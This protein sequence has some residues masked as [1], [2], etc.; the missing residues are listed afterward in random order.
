MQKSKYVSIIFSVVIILSMLLAGCQSA[1]EPVADPSAEPEA[2]APAAEAEAP[3]AVEE[4]EAPAPAAEPEVA[5]EPTELFV[6]LSNEPSN[7]EPAVNGGTAQRAVKLLIYRGLYNYGKDGALTPELASS[8]DISDD[9]LTYT[10]HLIDAVFHNGDPV[11]ADDVKFTFD[12]IANEET[13]ATFS[14]QLSVID[15]VNVVDEKTVEFVLSQP[16][17]PL[18]D[19]LALPESVIVSKNYSEANGGDINTAPVGAGPYSFVEYS[20][21]QRV[22]VQKF[23]GYYKEG[24]PVTDTITFM[25]YPDANTRVTALQAG[26]VDIIEY[27]PWKDVD[28]IKSDSS[29]QILG[30]TGPFMGLIFNTTYGPFSDPLVR[31]A[32]AYAIDRQVVIDTAFS[33]AGEQIFGMNVPSSSLAYDEKFTSYFSYDPE[34]AKQMLAEAGYPDGFKARLLATSQYEFH[35]NTAIAVQAELAKIGIEVEL[36]LPDWATRLEQNLAGDYDFLVV[37]TAGD[38]ADPDFLSD[39]YQSG[40]IRLNNAPGYANPEVDELLAQGR[41]A[42]D[43]AERKEIY[44]RLQEIVLEESPLVYLMWRDQ[45]YGASASVKDFDPLPGFLSFQSGIMLENAYK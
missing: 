29:L 10:F 16:M 36:D 15:S 7:W 27:V 14:K 17:A 19:Y 37:G 34:I 20:S 33:G 24:L 44:S 40:E 43:P 35:Q 39:Y 31:R 13:G 21:G 9:G 26:D 32:I 30:G 22:V 11:T 4:S 42:V 23:D 18:L 25:F 2:A 5:A 3:V 45:S 6:G 38:V 1:A 12:R 28:M 41:A 8:V